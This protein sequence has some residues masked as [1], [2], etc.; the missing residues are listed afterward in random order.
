MTAR[1]PHVEAIT[2]F[3]EN[4]AWPSTS[5][6]GKGAVAESLSIARVL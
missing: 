3:S 4:G 2:A 1:P 6:A 5:R